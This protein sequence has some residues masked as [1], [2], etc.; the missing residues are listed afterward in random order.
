MKN[1]RG[2]VWGVVLSLL[3]VFGSFAPA[4]VWSQ[5]PESM[6][7]QGDLLL[8]RGRSGG[9]R[10]GGYRRSSSTPKRSGTSKKT[11]ASKPG[12]SPD[13]SGFEKGKVPNIKTKPRKLSPAD[14]KLKDKA[15]KNGTSFKS[16]KAASKDFKY[17]HGKDYTS[18]YTTKPATRPSHIPNTYS[19][20]GKTYNVS[21][22]SGYG[23]YGYMGPSGSWMMYDAMADAAMLS[24]LMRNHSYFVE[25][26]P[27]PVNYRPASAL[28]K[29]FW[30][31]LVLSVIVGVFVLVSIIR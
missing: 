21:Y 13:K 17:K 25:P 4:Q 6:S 11:K 16:R 20:G 19:S 10:S 8:A 9:S 26:A 5:E 24:I 15:V 22:N 18:T 28:T 1:A 2:I 27:M 29:V 31:I 30:F 14:Q 23:G 12:G 3:V 7:E